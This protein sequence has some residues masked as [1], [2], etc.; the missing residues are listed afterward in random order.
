MTVGEA[1]GEGG[2]DAIFTYGSNHSKIYY[3]VNKNIVSILYIKGLETW[4]RY[5]DLYMIWY[6]EL[7]TDAS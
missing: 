3:K 2:E 5:D 7:Y 6:A 4:L 1:G